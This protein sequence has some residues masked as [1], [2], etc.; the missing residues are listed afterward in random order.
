M[1][2][3]QVSIYFYFHFRNKKYWESDEK[4]GKNSV[5]RKLSHISYHYSDVGKK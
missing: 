1:K 5:K 4:S 2:I 3:T